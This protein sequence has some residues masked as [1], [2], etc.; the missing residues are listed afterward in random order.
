MYFSKISFITVLTFALLLGACQKENTSPQ[1]VSESTLSVA[2]EVSENEGMFDDVAFLTDEQCDKAFKGEQDETEDCPTRTWLY[3]LGTFP[4]TLT[5]DFGDACTNAK[6]IT[7]SGQIVIT[8][9]DLPQNAGATR[10]TTLNNYYVDGRHIE[11][12]RTWTNNGAD[13]NGNPSFTETLSG[14][15]IT[16]EDGS[17]NTWESSHTVSQIAGNDTDYFMDDMMQITGGASGTNKD[18]ISFL[19]EI[20]TPLIKK[21][22]CPWIVSGV[23]SITLSDGNSRS[24][25]YGDGTCDRDAILTVND[26]APVMI[27]LHRA[28]H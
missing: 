12:T 18:G 15:V 17:Q 2:T 14:G 23:R 28:W 25:D 5:I 7:R 20:T 6:G 19:S 11:G 4:N 13:E 24:L 9:S 22:A 10:T 3:D 1:S 16:F 21:R 27:K 8:V 26:E